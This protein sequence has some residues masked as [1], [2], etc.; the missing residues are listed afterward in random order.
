VLMC[1]AS[2]PHRS[3]SHLIIE[4]MERISA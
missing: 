1:F 2:H 3:H 4:E